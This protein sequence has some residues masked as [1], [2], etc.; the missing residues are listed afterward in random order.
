MP[1]SLSRGAR[2][3]RS[4]GGT[5]RT[6]CRSDVTGRGA[7]TYAAVDGLESSGDLDL[8]P[9]ALGGCK[10]GQPRSH[11]GRG[12]ITIAPPRARA[13][14]RSGLRRCGAGSSDR[15]LHQRLQR[16]HD[17]P[18]READEGAWGP[19][20]EHPAD[21]GS[22]E[23]PHMGRRRKELTLD[24]I[25]HDILRKRFRE[26]RVHFALVCA[27]R[28]C[29]ALPPDMFEGPDL[30][31]QLTAAA[32]VFLLDQ[33]RNE[34]TPKDGKI[35]ISKIFDWYQDDFVAAAPPDTNLVRLYGAKR[36]AAFLPATD[37]PLRGRESASGGTRPD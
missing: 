37:A 16:V 11:P 20:D 19:H 23:P 17:R 31:A 22:V 35:R 18:H 15:L 14:R 32:H 12:S 13:E 25:E 2:A 27:S 21:T 30:R 9:G 29:P 8:R 33:T 1:P 26:P 4:A 6:P 28:S 34:F 7:T 36:G 5:C 10:L 24:Q 3:A